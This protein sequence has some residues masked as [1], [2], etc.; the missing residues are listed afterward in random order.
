[1]DASTAASE[2]LEKALLENAKAVD[3]AARMKVVNQSCK[4]CHVKFRD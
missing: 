2:A 1:M 4:D 3:L